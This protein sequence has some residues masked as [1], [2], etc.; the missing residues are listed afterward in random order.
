VSSVMLC[1]VVLVR[2]DLSDELS[3]S[4]N[5]VT[6]IGELGTLALFLVHRFLSSLL[7]EALSFAETS[8]LTKATRRNIP[9]Y[10]ILHS[11]RRENLNSYMDLSSFSGKRRET[12]ARLGP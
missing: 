2:T 8:V 11:R 4:F 5:K 1:R 10:A 6:R 7:K 3:G 12:P 9:E